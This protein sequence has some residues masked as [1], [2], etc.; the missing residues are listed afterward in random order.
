MGDDDGDG[1]DDDGVMKEV[2]HLRSSSTS[3]PRH[4]KSSSCFRQYTM[5]VPNFRDR[6]GLW[7]V[8]PLVSWYVLYYIIR[9]R[10]NSSNQIHLDSIII[11]YRDSAVIPE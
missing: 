6:R 5:T 7:N 9:I 10:K 8:F 3:Y 11:I 1:V 2:V 4:V